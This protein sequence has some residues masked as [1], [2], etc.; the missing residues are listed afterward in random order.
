MADDITQW[1]EGLGLG[2][3]AQAFAENDIDLRALPH[4]SDDDLNE[5][6]L[7]LGH[8]RILQGALKEQQATG[9]PAATQAAWN[10]LCKGSQCCGLCRV[11]MIG[12]VE[13][14]QSPEKSRSVSS[15]L[16]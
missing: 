13:P 3:Y 12:P 1:L 7:S 8:R 4:L 9:L 15:L 11:T 2:R 10:I 14:C 16:K 5:L 6:G